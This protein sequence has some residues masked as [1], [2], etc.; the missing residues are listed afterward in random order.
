M[1]VSGL[2]GTDYQYKRSDV[3][4]D[5]K[6]LTSTDFYKLLAAEYQYQSMDSS[7]DTSEMMAQMVQQNMIAALEKM[8]TTIENLNTSNVTSYAV[9]LMG[10]EVTVAQEEE[11][12]SITAIKGTVSGVNMGTPPSLTI[13][14]K[15]Y[16]LTQ[17]MT[18]GEGY[19]NSEE[20]TGTD[21]NTDA[22][23]DSSSG[24]GANA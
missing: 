16:Q 7:M 11:D 5:S 17:I 13:N 8:S 6:D 18:V 21:T 1:D 23:A 20:E 12:G 15:E 3:S 10:Q 24:P 19:S 4:A 2:S 9:N 22:D 14:G